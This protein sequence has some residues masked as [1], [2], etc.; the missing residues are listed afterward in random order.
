MLRYI[1]NIRYLPIFTQCNSRQIIYTIYITCPKLSTRNSLI[2]A[3]HTY[4]HT[5]H[6]IHQCKSMFA[7]KFRLIHTP[8]L[9]YIYYIYCTCIQ[10]VCRCIYT[11]MP[12]RRILYSIHCKPNYSTVLILSSI[13]TTY[14]NITI[15]N[16]RCS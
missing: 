12:H 4:Q 9:I 16:L 5:K 7:S 15:L 6:P 1:P 3:A 14:G 11:S 8:T 13:S 10:L 2:Q